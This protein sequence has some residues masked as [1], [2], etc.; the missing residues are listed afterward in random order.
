MKGYMHIYFLFLDPV[1]SRQ[2]VLITM[3][4]G[5]LPLKGKW[6]LFPDYVTCLPQRRLETSVST[7]VGI[8]PKASL[9]PQAGKYLCQRRDMQNVTPITRG[10]GR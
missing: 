7:N 10:G 5:D 9:F 3:I 4:L 1:D 2:E 8:L 6:D